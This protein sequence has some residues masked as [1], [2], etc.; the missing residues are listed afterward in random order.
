MADDE[1]PETTVAVLKQL[2]PGLVTGAADDDPS[3]IATH[4][5]A[6]A[7]FGLNMLWTVIVCLPLMLAIQSIAARI[8]AVTGVG[9][10][11]NMKKV[12]PRWVL[13]ALVV[14]LLIANTINIAADV[15]AMAEAAVLVVPSID[16]HLYL[17]AFAV[18]SLLLQVFVA[19]HRYVGV[20]KWLTLALL[21]YLAVV[22]TVKVPWDQVAIRTLA[23]QLELNKETLTMVM[24]ILGT[25][26]SP[27]LFFWQSAQ[28]VEDIDDTSNPNVVLKTH[29]LAARQGLRRI[30][31]DTLVG[32]AFCE[33]IAFAIM[34]TTAVTLNAHHITNIDSA[35]KAAEALRPIAGPF[36][37]LVFSLGII[38]TGLLAI[39]VLAGSA[40]Y[41]VSETMGWK[42]G[43][44]S[45]LMQA[46]GFYAVI[47]LA[48]LGGLALSFSPIDPIKA[49]VW[50]A[51]I[52]GLAAVPIMA[53]T[54][55]VVV[56]KD[57]MGDFIATPVQRVVGWL[58]TAA[59]C[60]AAVGMIVLMLV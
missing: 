40:A 43:L 33:L 11:A 35:A 51:V 3:G 53:V 5:Q 45:K 17:V 49:L 48:T 24:A 60:A 8:G 28:E 21:A 57:L 34:L 38:G 14:L 31:L 56:R 42:E 7:Q 52:N 22:F 4:S 36:A 13:I 25:T 27:Y 15:A 10:A 1:A 18:V 58:A 44:N 26:I 54:M 32:M 16:F 29:P 12:F 41:A 46:K 20:L 59:M 19:Y 9:L 55:V 30:R 6:G 37:S 2:G 47:A 39:P 50:S 23:P